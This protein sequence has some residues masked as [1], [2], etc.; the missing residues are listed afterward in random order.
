MSD[1]FDHHLGEE[2]A[3]YADGQP[4]SAELEHHLTTCSDCQAALASAR[5]VLKTVDANK[6]PLPSP[7]FDAA[8][9]ARLEAIDRAESAPWLERLRAFFTLP[10]LGLV[11][12]AAAV[13]VLLVFAGGGSSPEHLLTPDVAQNLDSF[14]LA[15]DLDLYR[16][17][18]LAENLDELDDL[19]AIEA[20]DALEGGGEPG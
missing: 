20:M 12:A 7:G 16:D 11:A 18:E 8:M 10:K 3:A 13:V 15:E 14:A 9:F 17:L 4:L 2:L 6:P 1:T 19:E 5:W